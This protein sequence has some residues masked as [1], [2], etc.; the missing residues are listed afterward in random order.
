MCIKLLFFSWN[1]TLQILPPTVYTLFTIYRN[2]NQMYFS[3][4]RRLLC[5]TINNYLDGLD[6]VSPVEKCCCCLVTK[7]CLT[8]CDLV[9]GSPPASSVRGISPGSNTGLSC[10]FL[11]QGIF[12]TQRS[13]PHLLCLSH[14]QVESLPLSHLGSPRL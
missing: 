6:W 13:N 14:W 8:L 12:L 10:Y 2:M 7:L 11:L 1:P 4:L 9:D 3:P 5:G